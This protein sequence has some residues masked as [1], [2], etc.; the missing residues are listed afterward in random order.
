MVDADCPTTSTNN[1]YDDWNYD[2]DNIKRRRRR[3][4]FAAS[5]V[6]GDS[7]Y[8]INSHGMVT[9]TNSSDYPDEDDP[10][11]IDDEEEEEEEDKKYT[12]LV[13]SRMIRGNSTMDIINLNNLQDVNNLQAA[14]DS[15]KTIIG[16]IRSKG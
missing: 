1:Y 3:K 13:S 4:C 8:H 6:M 10:M 14:T 5:I 16:H 12:P 9:E 11:L 2:G 15:S 7:L